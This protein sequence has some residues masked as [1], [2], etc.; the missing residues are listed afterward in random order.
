M[1][2][3]ALS[4]SARSDSLSSFSVLTAIA[5][6]IISSPQLVT[7]NGRASIIKHGG[8]TLGVERWAFEVLFRQAVYARFSFHDC[9]PC[10]LSG[11]ERFVLSRKN[12]VPAY[13]RAFENGALQ[14]RSEE[15]IESLRWCKVW[16]PACAL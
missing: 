3:T 8:W 11:G 2:L 16:P 1:A 12:F 5:L 7:T 14:Q 15:A 4:Q 13:V 10:E 6:I 9:A